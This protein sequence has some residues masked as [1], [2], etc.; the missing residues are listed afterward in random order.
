MAIVMRCEAYDI[1]KDPEHS[2][3][4]AGVNVCLADQLRFRS[5]YTTVYGRGVGVVE[6]GMFF[7]RSTPRRKPRPSRLP[8]PEA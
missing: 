4:Q 3:Q 6:N 7:R 5:Q 1:E 8:H 2:A